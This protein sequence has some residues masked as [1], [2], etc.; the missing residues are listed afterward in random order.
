MQCRWELRP[1][2]INK[3]LFIHFNKDPQN[4]KP[5]C[6]THMRAQLCRLSFQLGPFIITLHQILPPPHVLK[7]ITHFNKTCLQACSSKA[8][9]PPHAL[10]M[11]SAFIQTRLV[12]PWLPHDQPQILDGNY[13]KYHV[14]LTT[15]LEWTELSLNPSFLIFCAQLHF[16]VLHSQ[17]VKSKSS[18]Q[19]HAS[20]SAR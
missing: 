5:L 18:H 4:G 12:F 1:H 11:I 8:P 3:L 15:D 2:P 10:N 20:T 6:E 17:Q 13:K 14:P 16:P 19:C 9:L 7:P